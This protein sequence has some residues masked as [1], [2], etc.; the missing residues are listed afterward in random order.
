MVK[1]MQQHIPSSHFK[2]YNWVAIHTLTML[3][4]HRH[5]H[6][7]PPR[8]CMPILFQMHVRVRLHHDFLSWWFSSASKDSYILAN[9][10]DAS[11]S[12]P[13][14]FLV[15]F[16]FF[17]QFFMSF[18]S[19]LVFF[20]FASRMFVVL[21]A[22]TVASQRQRWMHALHAQWHLGTIFAFLLLSCSSNNWRL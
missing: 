13:P 11:H 5:Y 21:P 18:V 9:P 22:P 20:F 16:F 12:A 7:N 2:V 1:H 6:T 17:L 3:Y 14:S 8:P 19:T 15:F 10:T 4:K